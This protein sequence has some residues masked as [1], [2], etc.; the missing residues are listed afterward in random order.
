M[1]AMVMGSSQTQQTKPTQVSDPSGLNEAKAAEAVADIEENA[2]ATAAD[3]EASLE[4]AKKESLEKGDSGDADVRDNNDGDE[5]S[6]EKEIIAKEDSG[7]GSD[8]SRKNSE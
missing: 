4:K 7:H 2:T 5:E 8:Q 3:V 1:L 6:F